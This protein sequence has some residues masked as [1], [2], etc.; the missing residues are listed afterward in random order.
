MT[1][2][3]REG[4]NLFELPQD[5]DYAR[6]GAGGDTY[7][8]TANG[9]TTAPVLASPSISQNHAIAA[10]GITTTPVLGTP[11]V[12][13]NYA[14]TANG[15]TTTPALASP[16]ITQTHVLS[17][18]AVAT[19]PVL[20]TTA[21]TQNH[22]LAASG[23]TTTP[24]LASPS[25][26]S[27]AGIQ[28]AQEQ[29]AQ[30]QAIILDVLI[31]GV[32]SSAGAYSSLPVTRKAKKVAKAK[33]GLTIPKEWTKEGAQVETSLPIALLSTALSINQ[34][35]RRPQL[36]RAFVIPGRRRISTGISVAQAQG[37][38]STDEW[39]PF[40]FTP[41]VNIDSI[42]AWIGRPSERTPTR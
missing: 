8:L 40:V 26:F 22:D 7:A 30:E 19:T 42:D 41:G 27:G 10:S 11:A 21:L 14:I 13:Q 36:Q 12:T 1:Q 6:T 18:T 16:A 2:G 32:I 17:A 24:V 33:H 37:R 29:A 35:Q 25:L 15:I 20:G 3:L 23:I 31:Q 9:I 38:Q 34:V 4:F 28:V 39:Q 5:R